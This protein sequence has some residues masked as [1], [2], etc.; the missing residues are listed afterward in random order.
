VF[1]EAFSQ[2]YNLRQRAVITHASPI[3]GDQQEPFYVFPINGYKFLYSKE[4]KDSASDYNHVIDTVFERFASMDHAAEIVTDVVK[5]SYTDTNLLEGLRAGAEIILYN[6]PYFYAVK[7]SVYPD[8]KTLLT[9]IH[10]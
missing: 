10:N 9:H 2:V 7:Q 4:V 1:N 6:I 3:I 5:A 8:Y